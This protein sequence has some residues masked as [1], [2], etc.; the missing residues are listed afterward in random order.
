MEK[1]DLHHEFPQFEA[2]IHD[3]KVNDAHFRKLFDE[4]H[5]VNNHIHSIESGATTAS[6]E[7]LN[8]FR[9]RRVGLKD[10]LFKL[11]SA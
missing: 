10:Q 8:E 3:M 9:H 7:H 2:K 6:D 1:H 5:E 11:L 4:Y